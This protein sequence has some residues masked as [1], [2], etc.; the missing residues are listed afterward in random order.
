MSRGFCKLEQTI[1]IGLDDAIVGAVIS[2]RDI[3][4][5]KRFGSKGSG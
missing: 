3:T 4:E 1:Y 2:F 5:R